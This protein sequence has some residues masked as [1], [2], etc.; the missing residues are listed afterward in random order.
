M[1]A[2]CSAVGGPPPDWIVAPSC[3]NRFPVGPMT[4]AK[5]MIAA[6]AA[7]APTP[8]VIPGLELAHVPELSLMSRQY[9]PAPD[10]IVSVP[11]APAAT[12]YRRLPMICCITWPPAG[13]L[14]RSPGR[15]TRKTKK[16]RNR[17]AQPHQNLERAVHDDPGTS[18]L[19]GI[20]RVEYFPE[21]KQHD[22]CACVELV[23][24]IAG[25]A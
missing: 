4:V 12:G 6:S 21:A 24:E 5:R 1:V 20:A 3:N 23:V 2:A 18:S 7:S 9:K 15:R 17:R 16:L 11:A 25:D 22:T 8:Y 14:A 10:R 13:P 19:I